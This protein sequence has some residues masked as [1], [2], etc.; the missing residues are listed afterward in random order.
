MV[1]DRRILLDTNT[2]IGLLRDIAPELRA[3][4]VGMDRANRMTSVIVEAELLVGVAKGREPERRRR[5]L[6]Q[7]LSGFTVQEFTRACADHY[8]DIRAFVERTG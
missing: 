1:P 2:I 6:D 3:A 5:E 7:L 4:L 8:A